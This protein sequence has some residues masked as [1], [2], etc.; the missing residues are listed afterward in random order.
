MMMMMM[1]MMML[2]M[3][4]L[5]M[6]TMKILVMMAIT[7]LM[8][9]IFS[10]N[11]NSYQVSTTKFIQKYFFRAG[12]GVWMIIDYFSSHCMYYRLYQRRSKKKLSRYLCWL[13]MSALTWSTF[14]FLGQLAPID[15]EPGRDKQT[16]SKGRATRL[17][18]CEPLSSQF[19][20]IRQIINYWAKNL[21]TTKIWQIVDDIDFDGRPAF[22]MLVTCCPECFGLRSFQSKSNHLGWDQRSTP[23]TSW[24][25]FQWHWQ[26]CEF[27]VF[28]DRG[29]P[30]HWTISILF[31]WKFKILNEKSCCGRELWAI[32]GGRWCRH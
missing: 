22:C 20:T 15:L 27:W 30:S 17:L 31:V 28:D 18:I 23:I 25:D 9:L 24:L 5:F 21:W 12:T 10:P 29:M 6:M 16:T 13:P 19:L 3:M 11:T 14:L 4:T 32:M 1:M 2:V 7:V 26:E 8:G